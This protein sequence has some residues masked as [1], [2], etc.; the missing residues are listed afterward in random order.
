MRGGA[1]EIDWSRSALGRSFGLPA[2]GSRLSAPGSVSNRPPG[3]IRSHMRH[4]RHMR[5]A[6]ATLL[7]AAALVGCGRPAGSAPPAPAPAPAAAAAPRSDSEALVGVPKARADSV[8]HPYTDADVRF[9]TAMIAH[10]AQAIRMSDLAPSH[11]AS[12]SV[13]TLAERIINSQRDE[14][15]T[16]QRWLRDREKPV[17]DPDAPMQMAGMHDAH[18]AG[19]HD[20]HQGMPGMRAM[21]GTS[22]DSLMPGMLSAEQMKQLDEARG[23]EFDRL[24]LTFMI[25]HHRGA[26]QMVKRLFDS[27]GAGQDDT[28]FKFASDVNV[29]QTTEIARMERMLAALLFGGGTP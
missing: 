20:A 12:P 29:D 1:P 23:R 21:P 8:R 11:G 17:P 6:G 9:M 19:A 25:Q 4:M 13:L 2:V 16:M 15:G 22:H 5:T 10:H 7:A 27:Y 3:M 14:I 26:V 28:V 18:G 24:F